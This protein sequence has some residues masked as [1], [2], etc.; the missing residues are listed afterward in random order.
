MDQAAIMAGLGCA[1]EELGKQH[2][3]L[4]KERTLFAAVSSAEA[5]CTPETA[6]LSQMLSGQQKLLQAVKQI[7]NWT[8]NTSVVSQDPS[9]AALRESARSAYQNTASTIRQQILD[10]QATARAS[11][12]SNG[13]GQQ[14]GLMNP[15]QTFSSLLQGDSEASTK[16]LS[17][18]KD[19][20]TEKEQRADILNLIIKPGEDPVALLGQLQ[21][22]YD[23][24]VASNM[25]AG[26]TGMMGMG[27]GEGVQMN[28][29]FMFR[30]L[31]ALDDSHMGPTTKLIRD[32]LRD[33]ETP[34]L[35]L[36][37]LNDFG[38]TVDSSLASDLSPEQTRSYFNQYFTGSDPLDPSPTA[39]ESLHKLDTALAGMRKS[40]PDQ[41]ASRSGLDHLA[42]E[43]HKALEQ[44]DRLS[45]G[46]PSIQEQKEFIRSMND[47]VGRNR[48]LY[49]QL[50]TVLNAQLAYGARDVIRGT[51]DAGA[52]ALPILLFL[53]RE[54][55]NDTMGISNNPSGRMSEYN[56]AISLSATQIEAFD[57]FARPYLDFAVKFLNGKDV[58][59]KDLPPGVLQNMSPDLKNR[60]CIQ[61]LSMG[62]LPKDLLALCRGTGIHSGDLKLSFD[63]FSGL[64]QPERSCAYYNFSVQESL[65]SQNRLVQ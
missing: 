22:E 28:A 2:C 6:K 9:S 51:R 40:I 64:A 18:I 20:L 12:G 21:N 7:E 35:I 45:I 53:N 58:R 36:T 4:L 13:V 25:R 16:G 19:L 3:R 30:T 23:A 17:L 24:Y 56:Q 43:V 57:R 44:S 65:Q 46:D 15:L 31:E 59:G 33:P 10:I 14:E 63:S 62:E 54:T 60:F 32:R 11:H 49:T 29:L 41:L 34:Q 55:L 48:E 26:G 50:Q 38:K 61:T 42:S 27:G 47:F 37:R 1:F 5:N 39:A 52:A 8:G